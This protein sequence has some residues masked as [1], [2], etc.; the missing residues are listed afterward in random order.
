VIFL[1]QA[2]TMF[3]VTLGAHQ[4]QHEINEQLLINNKHFRAVVHTTCCASSIVHRTNTIYTLM[5]LDHPFCGSALSIYS[6]N[7]LW[8]KFFESVC[9]GERALRCDVILFNKGF[10]TSSVGYYITVYDMPFLE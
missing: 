1:S 6:E 9:V 3:V 7:I 2:L 5:I 10:C 8:Q 4:T